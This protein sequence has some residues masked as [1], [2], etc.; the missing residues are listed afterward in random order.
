[1]KN[2]I[3][4]GRNGKQIKHHKP[5]NNNNIC[6]SLGLI[7]VF[8]VLF[9]LTCGGLNFACRD[10]KCF[11]LQTPMVIILLLHSLLFIQIVLNFFLVK[12]FYHKIWK[13]QSRSILSLSI[14]NF[15][16]AWIAVTPFWDITAYIWTLEN[17]CL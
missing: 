7:H 3:C 14:F 5:F 10:D 1:M 16:I 4:S 6:P 12:Y 17:Q 2:K 8:G 15:V 13:D 9:S 11:Q